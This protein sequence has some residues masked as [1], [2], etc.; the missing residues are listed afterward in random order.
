MT[1]GSTAE[2]PAARPR[3]P[4]PGRDHAALRCHV[5]SVLTRLGALAVARCTGSQVGFL[6]ATVG[7]GRGQEPADRRALSMGNALP[8][9]HQAELGDRRATLPHGKGTTFPRYS[10]AGDQV[11]V[12]LLGT[13]C[14]LTLTLLTSPA[15]GCHQAARQAAV[16]SPSPLCLL[17]FSPAEGRRS[18]FLRSRQQ[19]AL[20]GL[21][22]S[23][24]HHLSYLSIALFSS[25]DHRGRTNVTFTVH[26]MMAGLAYV[27][28]RRPQE[29]NIRRLMQIRKRKRKRMLFLVTR[30]PRVRSG[31][32]WCPVAT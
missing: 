9:C 31:Q 2:P 30:A 29:V 1:A 28:S 23:R 7:R 20:S 21:Q 16:L 22:I 6:K 3:R 10:R 12:P 11:R 25:V 8:V 24:Y 18:S 17:A 13:F 19:L 15:N 5:S 26:G 14:V 4:I 32:L 27:V